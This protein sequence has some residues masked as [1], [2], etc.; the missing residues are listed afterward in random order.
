MEVKR[1]R[2]ETAR[3]PEDWFTGDVYLDTLA[4]PAHPSRVGVLSVHFTPGARTAW[5]KHPFGQILYVLEGEGR[6][7]R[8]GGPV[9]AIR[10]GDVIRFEPEEEHWHGASPEHLMTHVAI[11]EADDEGVP[12]YWGEHVS[13]EEYLAE[14][15][16]G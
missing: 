9:E 14:P 2:T 7:Q 4:A 3:G 5:H 13:D 6:V 12:A 8:R 16:P 10:A 11:Q 1:D 15:G